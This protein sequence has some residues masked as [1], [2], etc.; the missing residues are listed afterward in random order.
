M[1]YT[2]EIQNFDGGL[3]RIL[4]IITMINFF[5]R[6]RIIESEPESNNYSIK[7]PEPRYTEAEIQ[8]PES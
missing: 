8:D 2:N 3:F 4:F 1:A 5:Y 7:N 6:I